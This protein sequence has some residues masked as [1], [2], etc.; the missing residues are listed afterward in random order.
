MHQCTSCGSTIAGDAFIPP[1]LPSNDENA[2]QALLLNMDSDLSDFDTE[3]DRV[4]AV[5]D[6]LQR[7]RQLLKNAC[8]QYR[9]FLSPI[10]NLPPE[11]LSEIFIL[12]IAGNWRGKEFLYRRAVMLPGSVC[13]YWR[14]VALSTGRLWSS[15][16]L[17]LWQDTVDAELDLTRTWLA[18]SNGSPLQLSLLLPGTPDRVDSID[19]S[20]IQVI[21]DNL[22][23]HSELWQHVA[24]RL[25][26][27]IF[28]KIYF[29]TNRFPRLRSL[30]IEG[31]PYMS[32]ATDVF[33]FT[34]QLTSVITNLNL[35]QSR[36]PWTQL[37]FIRLSEEL[38]ID[39]CY[40]VLHM[41][42]GLVECHLQAY[43]VALD[44][45][46]TMVHRDHL[47]ILTIHSICW[48]GALLDLLSLPVLRSFHYHQFH[49]SAWDHT[50]F[51][52]F[53]SRSSCSLETLSLRLLHYRMPDNDLID[54]LRLMPS[55]R[56]LQLKERSGTAVTNKLLALLTLP[57][58]ISGEQGDYLVPELRF[59]RI[60]L[61]GGFSEDALASMVESRQRSTKAVQSRG[62]HRIHVSRLKTLHLDLSHYT[63]RFDPSTFSRLHNCGLDVCTFKLITT[64]PLRAILKSEVIV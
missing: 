10:R 55:L 40:Q 7:K 16:S 61:H 54:Y 48:A 3:I 12:N 45:S 22:I 63:G 31:T 8:H 24:I 18:R 60:C 47:Q 17:S 53:L 14:S 57:Q 41:A 37:T 25:P 58:S 36:I 26:C 4:Q 13:R 56:Y 11:I 30:S 35:C 43:G 51:M 38:T 46:H 32:L 33:E 49:S 19:Q 44:S 29:A 50:Q 52:S 62:L 27:D 6:D 5:L 59:M 20:C 1:T 64:V 21:V 42:P 28:M 39:E 15:I 34:P 23:E 9:A 2:I